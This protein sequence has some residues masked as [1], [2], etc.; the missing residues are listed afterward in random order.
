M[1]K[2]KFTL[3]FVLSILMVMPTKAGWIIKQRNFDSDEGLEYAITETVYLQDGRMK[4]VQSEMIT[5][6]DLNKEVITIINPGKKVY[7]TGNVPKYK[8]EIKAAMK[9]TMDEQLAN[10][11]EAQKEMITKMYT[12]MIESIDNPAK[13]AGEEPEEYELTIEK[14]SEKERIAGRL[15]VKYKVLVNGSVKEESWLSESDRANAEFDPEKFHTVFGDFISQAG[16]IAYYQVNEKYYEF[17]KKGFPLKSINYYGGY[18]SISE[19]ISLDREKIN[20]SEFD[21]PV[22][23]KSVNLIEIGLN[24]QE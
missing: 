16:T 5:I 12:G 18:E 24:E 11:P 19:V 10:A 8:K 13:F 23:F 1:K 15:A 4:V 22:G 3:L 17:S 7:W 20:E 9:S 2:Y 21:V 14:T 6:F